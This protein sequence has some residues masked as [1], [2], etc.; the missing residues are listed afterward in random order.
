MSIAK[1]RTEASL[2]HRVRKGGG[3]STKQCKMLRKA[4]NDY[5][6]AVRRNKRNIIAADIA[7]DAPAHYPYVGRTYHEWGHDWSEDEFG[8]WSMEQGRYRE[9]TCWPQLLALLCQQ[10]QEGSGI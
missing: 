4:T 5:H 10:F 1:Y 6:R 3:C 2:A 7:A 9:P 8:V